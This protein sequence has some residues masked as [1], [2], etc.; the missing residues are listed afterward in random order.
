MKG[1][2]KYVLGG[3]AAV[4]IVAVIVLVAVL[5]VRNNNDSSDDTVY[6]ETTVEYGSITVGITDEGSV[7][8]GTVEQTFDLDI[9]A[10]VSS[11][12]SS[13]SSG[14]MGQMMQSF[15]MG[16]SSYSSQSQS[17][18]VESVYVTVGQEISEGDVIYTFTEDSVNEIRQ[19]LADD[20]DETLNDYEALLVEQQE[21]RNTAQQGYD[22]Y[23]TN[24]KF[25]QLIYDNEIEEL[26]EAVDDAEDAVNDKQDDLN[27]ALL[28]LQEKQEDLIE[29]NEYLKEA[30]N[31]VAENYDNRY[32][33]P[34]YYTVYENTRETAQ[35]MVDD[36]EDEIED[37]EDEIESLQLEIESAMRDYRSAYIELQQGLLSSQETYD[38]DTYYANSASEWY[39]IQTASIDSEIETAKSSYE[40]AQSKLEKFD[41][42]IV[43]NSLIS[44]YSGVITSAELAE[45]DTVTKGTGL[46]VLYDQEDVTMDISLAEDDYEMLDDDCQVNITYTAYPD[47]VYSAVISDV[48]DATY[49][50]STG[51]I[52]YTL[53]VTVQGDV[54]GLY[55]GMTGDVTFVT[56][57][58]EDVLYV[59][60][61]AIN[62]EGTRSYVKVRNAAGDIE[63]KDVVTG[64]SDG[65][66][67][68]IVEGLS[69]G[70]IVL[71]EGKVS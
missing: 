64:F 27:E 6:R 69:E 4:A 58:T 25:A 1:K 9:S 45:G 18:E 54:S 24:G 71:I 41:A 60:N 15:S 59:S 36:L 62:R 3:I 22:T 5:A 29:A 48:S 44:E 55:E 49:D 31:A 37:L 46:I 14:I 39:S 16:G 67:V 47:V 20:V 35:Q 19:A 70:D 52:Y 42:Y 2:I 21:T 8:I 65:T 33:E 51:S 30:E 34:Y 11:D 43:D 68:E 50:S 26:Q 57:E 40:T 23:V 7:S 12:S 32:D 17:L 10:L 66:Y 56:N 38:I 63:E 13:S 28:D 53:T 61:R